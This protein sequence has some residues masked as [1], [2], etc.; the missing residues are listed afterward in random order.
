MLFLLRS[1]LV[2]V[3]CWC[4]PFAAAH[5]TW[6]LPQSF[7]PGESGMF[8]FDL[9]SGMAFPKLEAAIK[10]ER[11]DSARLWLGGKSTDLVPAAGAASLR[12]SAAVTQPGLAA[13]GIS[14][15]PRT[16]ELDRA[17]VAHYL[18]EIAASPEIRAQA[19]R[20]ARWRESYVKHAK[21]FVEVSP[22]PDDR[23][24]S[25]PV[26]LVLEII[27][28]VNPMTLR[29]G[30]DLPLRVLKDGKPLA[31]FALNLVGAGGGRGVTRRTDQDGRLTFRLEASGL[32]LVR[33][34]ELRAVQS[35]ELDWESD[36]TTLTLRVR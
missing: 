19:R 31:G 7:Q 32:H 30:D 8:Q 15:K 36:F 6:L 10:P 4:L 12:F 11:V 5:D 33:G 16:L 34:T 21:T 22:K 18:D 3:A 28:G 9:T 14:L 20:G 27:P 35:P 29:K 13:V 24:W 25:E 26:G 23:S 17:K 1:A 2:A